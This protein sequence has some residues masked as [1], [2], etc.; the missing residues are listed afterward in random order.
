VQVRAVDIRYLYKADGTRYDVNDVTH[1]VKSTS[2][3]CTTALAAQ[4]GISKELY[5]M[6]CAAAKEKVFSIALTPNYNAAHR[7]HFHMDIGEAGAAS[8][9]TV[10]SLEPGAVDDCAS[11]RCGDE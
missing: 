3:T 4:S 11:D 7:N 2:P 1:W 5:T 10:K 8:G 9:F 6:V